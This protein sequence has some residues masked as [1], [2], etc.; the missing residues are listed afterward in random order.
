MNGAFVL[1]MIATLSI[2]FNVFF[3]L[4]W[5]DALEGWRSAKNQQWIAEAEVVNLQHRLTPFKG[6]PRE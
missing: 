5:Q 4:K 1:L 3:W 6:L 2:C